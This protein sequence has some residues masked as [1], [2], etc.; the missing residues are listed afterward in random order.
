MNIIIEGEEHLDLLEVL[1]A[2]SMTQSSLYLK[3][4]YNHFPK[5]KKLPGV[6]FWKRSEIDKFLALR[7]KTDESRHRSET[8]RV[9]T[10][11]TGRVSM[12]RESIKESP[13]LCFRR[14]MSA[15]II[16]Q[17]SNLSG[18]HYWRISALEKAAESNQELRDL[19]ELLKKEESLKIVHNIS[20]KYW[21]KTDLEAVL[22]KINW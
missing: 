15:G 11:S 20:G 13:L 5:P 18:Q 19:Y 10:V 9:E 3:M 12:D 14:L 7:V 16:P 22:E 1:K 17:P 6:S 8:V 21:R 2:T 4:R